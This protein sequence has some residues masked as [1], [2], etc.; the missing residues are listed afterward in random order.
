MAA[1][2]FAW[3][4]VAFLTTP[5][6][7]WWEAFVGH[8]A[9]PLNMPSQHSLLYSALTLQSADASR[10][11]QKGPEGAELLI[12]HLS[13]DFGAQDPVQ[14]FVTFGDTRSVRGFL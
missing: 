11:Q 2:M 5:G 6:A 4:V 3:A 14:M 13:W 8:S 1:L 7:P 12:Y 9:M 10:N